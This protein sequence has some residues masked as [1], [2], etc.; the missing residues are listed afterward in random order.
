MLIEKLCPMYVLLSMNMR[1]FIVVTRH[2][3]Y[4]CMHKKVLSNT[5]NKRHFPDMKSNFLAFCAKGDPVKFS[6][7]YFKIYRITILNVNFLHT[8]T[9]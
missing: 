6:M 3:C 4:C 2:C 8:G 5:L 1:S 9:N 7:K